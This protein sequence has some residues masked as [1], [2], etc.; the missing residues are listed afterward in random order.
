MGVLLRNWNSLYFN[1]S[2]SSRITLKGKRN[3]CRLGLITALMMA[4]F[5][6]ATGAHAGEAIAP[7]VDAHE[8]MAAGKKFHRD[9][10]IESA[11]MLVKLKTDPAFPGQTSVGEVR[12]VYTILALTNVTTFDEE[13]HSPLPNVNIER[14]RGSDPESDFKEPAPTKKT[15]DVRVNLK[16]GERRTIVTGAKYTYTLPFPEKRNVH[17]FHDLTPREDVWGYPNTEDVIGELTILVESDAP[18]KTP[19][20][21]DA[22]LAEQ[23]HGQRVVHANTPALR[24]PEKESPAPYVLVARWQKVMPGQLVE[25][26]LAR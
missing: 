4:V 19:R 16:A 23:I 21:G 25:L 26:R 1:M 20:D 9:Y 5:V 12:L 10:V 18:L 22:L 7:G 15:W 13:F 3:L 11:T 2:S 14:I 6:T 8:M 17:D 24:A